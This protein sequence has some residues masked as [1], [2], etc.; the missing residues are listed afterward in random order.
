MFIVTLCGRMSKW[1]CTLHRH[2]IATLKQMS[3]YSFLSSIIH[4]V[5]DVFASEI[6]TYHGKLF[7]SRKFI[8]RI[9]T[10]YALCPC[11]SSLESRRCKS[12]RL[13]A[14]I[15]IDIDAREFHWQAISQRKERCAAVLSRSDSSSTL[16]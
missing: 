3:N 6:G 7:P 11:I 5:A 8:S 16:L 9:I 4:L 15:D 12:Y 2:D 10:R 13:F 1:N 14:N